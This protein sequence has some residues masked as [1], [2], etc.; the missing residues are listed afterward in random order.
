MSI[1]TMSQR[2]RE[3]DEGPSGGAQKLAKLGQSVGSPVK[4]KHIT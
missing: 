4:V 2:K 1:K 3:N